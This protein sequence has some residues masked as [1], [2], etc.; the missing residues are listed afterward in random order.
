M[1]DKVKGLEFYHGTSARAAIALLGAEDHNWFLSSM[2]SLASEVMKALSRH[3]PD[4]YKLGNIFDDAGSEYPSSAPLGI[5]E[6]ASGQINST[7]SYDQMWV[8][9]SFVGAAGYAKRHEHGSEAL[10]FLMEGIAVLE[11]LG[12]TSSRNLL[13]KYPKIQEITA[14]GHEPVVLTF[15]GID[16]E[17]VRSDRN[18]DVRWEKFFELSKILA[19]GYEASFRL[20]DPKPSDVTGIRVLEGYNPGGRGQIPAKED[21]RLL[22]PI[23][24]FA[25]RCSGIGDNV[26][27]KPSFC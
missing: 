15:S 16:P 11:F 9:T 17:R 3:Q 21:A 14:L 20:T 26:L 6:L 23:E 4:F 10:N 12:E 8:T 7:F 13:S 18:G 19:D 22:N 27:T 24:W 5:Q 25:Q 1:R 2:K